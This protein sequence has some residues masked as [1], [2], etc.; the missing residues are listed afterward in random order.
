MFDDATKKEIGKIA[1]DLGVE[2]AA[3]LAIAEVESSGKAVDWNNWPLIRWEGHYFHRF[4][5][6]LADKT[7]LNAAVAA[8]LANPKTGGVKNP[9]LQEDR[10]SLLDKAVAIDSDSALMSCSWG[11]GQVMG[12]NWKDLGYKSVQELVDRC[13]GSVAGQVEVM[14]RFIKTNGL[15]KALQKHDW[16]TFTTRYNGPSGITAGYDKKIGA[17]YKKYSAA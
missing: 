4:L 2:E 6:K 7:K 10:Y 8:G 3:L 12:S 17:A 13:K 15:V 16:K 1:K 11:L 14:A 9:K 5:S